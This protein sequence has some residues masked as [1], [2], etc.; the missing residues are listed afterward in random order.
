MLVHSFP[1]NGLGTTS[2]VSLTCW[3]LEGMQPLAHRL[4]C[5]SIGALY[6]TLTTITA[7]GQLAG[8]HTHSLG[9]VQFH[10]EP[11][12]DHQ[13]LCAALLIALPRLATAAFWQ[14]ADD[15]PEEPLL[16]GF[17]AACDSLQRRVTIQLQLNMANPLNT[18]LVTGLASEWVTVKLLSTEA[19]VLA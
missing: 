5:W 6:L 2:V 10:T 4:G 12:A 18:Q 1:S 14:D 16:L 11:G 9:L 19:H 3:L 17:A 8:A 7:L 13:A 15:M